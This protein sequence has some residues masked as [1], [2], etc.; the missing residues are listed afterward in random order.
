MELPQWNKKVHEQ[1]GYKVR[2]RVCA[3]CFRGDDILLVWHEGLDNQQYFIAPPGGG[4]QFGETAE[5]ALYREVQ[6][7]TGL[8]IRQSQFLF[9]YEYV[10]PPLH[11]IELFFAA[12]VVSGTLEG[13]GYDPELEGDSQ[14]IKQVKFTSPAEILDEEKSRFHQMIQRYHPPKKL[15][16]L[17]GYFKFDNK[18]RN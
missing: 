2:T 10:A 3:L 15:L 11:A 7:E 4:I 14:L 17:Q 18:T 12:E 6:E 13:I 5:Q 16:S 1:F 8:H 9:V